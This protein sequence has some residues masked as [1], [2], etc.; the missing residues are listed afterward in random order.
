MKIGYFDCFAGAAGD[1]I[2]GALIDAGCD[3]ALIESELNRLE[4]PAIKLVTEKVQRH[5]ISGTKVTFNVDESKPP[6]RGLGTIE[7][8]LRSSSLDSE[9]I[10]KSVAVFRRLAQ[11]EAKVHDQPIEKV[12]FHEVGA[13][14]AICDVVG[15][16]IALRELRV[17]KLYCSAL[18]FGSG[19][20]EAA[21]GKLPVPAPATVEIARGFPIKRID[22]GV[23][24]TTPT[25]AAILCE[26]AE[27]KAEPNLIIE[28]TGYG[29]GTRDPRDRPG[30][31]R[32]VLADTVSLLPTDEVVVIETNVDDTTPED[33]GHLQQ[34][35][36]AEQALDV[37]VTPV[38]MKKNRPAWLLTVICEKQHFDRLSQVL[39]RESTTA[40]LRYRHEQ[41][42]KLKREIKG[43]M[44]PYGEI[45]IKYLFGDDIRKFSPEYDDL[46]R[47]AAAAGVPLSWVRQ[48]AMQ[49]AA[50]HEG[51]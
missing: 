46:A 10:E 22:S 29:A 11:A 12:H 3:A 8:L 48:A 27:Y 9:I 26:L 44:T 6:H 24:M 5:G 40:G 34:R 38:Q 20:I 21:H 7:M 33:L 30:L 35:L 47:A 32:F 19:V 49:A 2:V 36:M 43:V 50:K 15:S 13:T 42:R 17:E 51:D 37:F 14:D 16:V 31:L 4:L 41:R 23:E 39:L 28:R 25:G 45:R 18:L 1:M